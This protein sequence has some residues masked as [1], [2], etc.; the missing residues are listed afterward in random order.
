MTVVEQSGSQSPCRHWCKQGHSK[1]RLKN[2][3]AS[4]VDQQWYDSPAGIHPRE[5]PGLAEMC[6]LPRKRS[7][8]DSCVC[9]VARA[10][11]LNR[12]ECRWPG[13]PCRDVLRRGH[14]RQ[15]FLAGPACSVLRISPVRSRELPS[16]V[17]YDSSAKQRCGSQVHFLTEF[18]T[19]LDLPGQDLFLGK[20]PCAVCR[21]APVLHRQSHPQPEG[22]TVL[23]GEDRQRAQ[24]VSG[25]SHQDFPAAR[26]QGLA[27]VPAR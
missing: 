11:V 4:R 2:M 14:A 16:T 18:Q 1:S 27:S 23:R 3:W 13:S 7:R 26:D 17:R 12:T 10:G 25:R 9:E 24:S 20:A 8:G 22:R 5:P 19:L 21:P 15:A 6:V